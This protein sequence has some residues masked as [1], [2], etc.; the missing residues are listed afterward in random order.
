MTYLVAIT[1]KDMTTAFEMRAALAK[2]QDEHLID[3]EDCVV[4]TRDAKGNVK[5]HQAVSV[6]ATGAS[7]GGFWGWL[8]G[9]ALLDPFLGA[10]AGAGAGAALGTTLGKL[11]DFGI[12]DQMMKDMG[13]S[14][15]PG[16][17]GVFVL[18]HKA[19]PDKV[20][21]GLKEFAGKGKVL[22]T[23]LTQG[24]E[25]ALRKVLE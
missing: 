9:L 12:N 4:V 6:T 22:K 14:F 5:L 15:T 21:A 13:A 20:L 25:A 3:M 7:I 17:S 16:S 2:M 10:V 1:F 18:L 24:T 19:N 8:I 11:S 23:S